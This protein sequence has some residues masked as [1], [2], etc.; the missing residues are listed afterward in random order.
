M[1]IHEVSLD[2]SKPS[3]LG[4]GSWELRDLNH[5][6]VVFG[7]NGSGKSAVLRALG[8]SDQQS[9]HLTSPERAGEINYQAS[10]A[11]E[12]ASSASR[13]ANRRYNLA[14]QFR[15]R[16]VS[17]IGTMINKRGFHMK[18][19]SSDDSIAEVQGFIK[20]VL[21]DFSFRLTPQNP[22]YELK[23]ADGS[24]VTD[25]NEISSGEVGMLTL[26]IDLT[27]VCA[28]WKL[29]S[30]PKRL[31]LIDEPDVHLHPDLQEHLASFLVKLMNGY[32]VQILVA[33]HSTTL[34]AALG[35]YGKEK[36]SALY[37]SG[38]AGPQSAV[39]FTKHL[40]EMSSCLGG[41]ALMGPLFGAPLL[42]VEG[43]DDYRIWSQVP[44]HHKVKLAALPC[45]GD[46]IF[47]YQK[48][49][50]LVFASI[51]SG[52]TKP[53]GYALIDGDKALPVPPP[54]QTQ[55]P[56]LQLACHEAENLYLADEVLTAMSLTW[57]EAVVKL[58]AAVVSDPAKSALLATSDTWNRQTEDI[59]SIIVEVS[60]IL[61]PTGVHWT[62]RLGSVLGKSKPSGQLATFLGSA[63]TT[64][65]WT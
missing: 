32:D 21:P 44:R 20:D 7:R 33:T 36:T 50:E 6:T 54:T 34:L 5:I 42:L 31:L 15:N 18:P 39:V 41:H 9:R 59:K 49:L 26:G 46:E 43:D 25:A 35:H 13:Y 19:G 51:R 52:M 4:G 62:K 37:L 12:E 24:A 29:E 30:Q 63:V 65:L 48:S 17:R 2:I 8:A 40:Q 11:D 64:A 47:K 22:Y 1:T 61:D 14:P 56:F 3:H 23:R 10:F 16:S 38:A 45:N 60:E 28:I 27:T 58:K 55:V 57:A 53:A